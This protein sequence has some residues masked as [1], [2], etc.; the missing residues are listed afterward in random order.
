MKEVRNPHINSFV[1]VIRVDTSKDL[2]H[3][4]VYVSLLGTDAEKTRLLEA[5]QSAAGF[6]AVNASKRVEL[7]YF[8]DL[9]FKLDTSLEEHLKIQGILAKLEQERLSRS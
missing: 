1:S 3:A 4:K 6:I 7:R 8:P 2:H 9:I 5:L